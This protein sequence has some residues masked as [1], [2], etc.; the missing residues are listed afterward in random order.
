MTSADLFADLDLRQA[1]PA[2]RVERYPDQFEQWLRD[3]NADAW[4]YTGGLENYPDLLD[5]LAGI[6]PLWG[7]DGQTV[8]RVRDPILLQ[9][10]LG[11]AGQLYPETLGSSE[12]LP[13]DGSWLC[14]AG[15]SGGLGVWELTSDASAARAA[16]AGT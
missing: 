4:V 14:K 8:R 9:R 11:E 10:A 3:A 7:N 15:G 13:R 2:T 12:G 5:R 6:K 1:G 16:A